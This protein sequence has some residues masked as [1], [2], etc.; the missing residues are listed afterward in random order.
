METKTFVSV[1]TGGIYIHICA[2][3]EIGVQGSQEKVLVG[4]V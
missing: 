4:K 1:K 3:R 2:E